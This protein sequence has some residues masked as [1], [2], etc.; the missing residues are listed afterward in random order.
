[1]NPEKLLKSIYLGDRACKAVLV[2]SWQKRVAIQVNVI[3]RLKPGTKTWD[4]YTDLDIKNGWLVFTDVRSVRFEPGGPLPNDLINDVSVNPIDP[5]RSQF[6]YLF[7]LSIGSVDDNGYS[8][9]VFVQVEASGLHIED[10][11]K[12][13]IEIQ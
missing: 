8:T 5:L 3:S 11:A 13:G 9:E 12:P 10:P 1:M 6:G 4:Y 7:E 2:D